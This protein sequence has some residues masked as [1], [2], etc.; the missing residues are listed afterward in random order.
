MTEI[1]PEDGI[2]R[3]RSQLGLAPLT[4]ARACRVRR[5][6]GPEKVYY[7][8]VFGDP[9]ATVAVAAV[10]AMTAEVMTSAVLRAIGPHLTVDADQALQKAR[11]AGSHA[12]LVW[13]P[14]RASFSPLYPFWQISSGTETIYVDQ[15]GKVWTTLESGGPGG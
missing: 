6:D 4:P 2:E 1:S 11:L 8:I 12:E 14:C 10:D 9:D 5:I 13:R 15:Q 3:A 7:L